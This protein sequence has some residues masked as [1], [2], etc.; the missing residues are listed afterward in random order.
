MNCET[1]MTNE[2]KR[3]EAMTWLA[4]RDILWLPVLIKIGD[5]GKKKFLD[6]EA[7]P[8]LGYIP[9]F[10]D[11]NNLEVAVIRQRMFSFQQNFSK[12]QKD[13]RGEDVDA[14][15]VLGVDTRS[16]FVLDVDDPKVLPFIQPLLQSNPYYLSTN[17]RLPKIF[18]VDEEMRLQYD[19]LQ[20]V[21]LWGDQLELQKG[22]WSFIDPDE[23]IYNPH[24]SFQNS[25]SPLIGLFPTPPPFVRTPT[26]PIPINPSTDDEDFHFFKD[27]EIFKLIS[28]LNIDR[29]NNW[30]QWYAVACALKSTK[31][32]YSFHIWKFFSKAGD[33]YDPSKFDEGGEDRSLWD[34]IKSDRQKKLTIAS[35]HYWAKQDNPVHYENFFFPSYDIVKQREES[36]LMKIQNPIMF[37]INRENELQY[38]N[39]TQLKTYYE[40]CYYKMK[41]ISVDEDGNE[42]VSKVN[43]PFIPR[44]LKDVDN[45]TYEKIVFEPNI[46]YVPHNHFNLFSGLQIEKLHNGVYEQNRVDQILDYILVRLCGGDKAFFD[47]FIKWLA[48]IVQKPWEKTKVCIIIKS[49][50]GIGKGLFTEFFG[51]KIVG[52]YLSTSKSSNILGHFTSLLEKKLFVNLDEIELK[53]TRDK[54]G[55]L[56]EL[57]TNPNITIEKKGV[58]PIIYKNHLNLLGTTNGANGI[59]PITLT[60][61]DRRYA[62]VESNAPMMTNEEGVYW[63]NFFDHPNSAWSFYQ[64][65]L[66]QELPVSLQDGRPMTSFYAECK[67]VTAGP[68]T[69]YWVH[70]L[71]RP[72]TPLQNEVFFTYEE[73]W[74]DYKDWSNA[75][76]R[77]EFSTEKYKSFCF[78]IRKFKGIKVERSRKE[79]RDIKGLLVN[80]KV[81]WDTLKIYDETHGEEVDVVSSSAVLD[82]KVK[83]EQFFNY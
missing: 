39:K 49:V 48:W 35:L 73:L 32:P 30:N 47:Y 17:K 12:L 51:E 36:C 2:V 20:N 59:A 60:H 34:S 45:K 3:I 56:N 9:K 10:D 66:N 43:V 50:E 77:Q 75:F 55:S 53:D 74:A 40:N 22:Q 16:V 4:D 27:H 41:S 57:I 24:S 78:N 62:G 46:E 61:G 71:Q 31:Y 67:S 79:G 11:F 6:F 64:F 5:D 14:Y 81:L 25:L 68:H 33:N 54:R 76:Y 63:H 7:R 69:H 23:P 44:W 80:R 83:Q 42:K 15:W 28:C 58:D 8:L 37:V 1:E 38:L 72:K 82:D 19:E 13:A 29:A 26:N 18:I 65:L 70:L 21:K 52:Y